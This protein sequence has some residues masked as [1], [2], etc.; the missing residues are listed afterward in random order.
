MG[1]VDA[2]RGRSVAQSQAN[3]KHKAAWVPK[4][5]NNDN[6]PSNKTLM[7]TMKPVKHSK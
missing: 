4:C 1:R 5:R 2:R 6:V 3:V 7:M